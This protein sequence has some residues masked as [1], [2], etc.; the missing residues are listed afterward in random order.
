MASD[1]YA[2]SKGKKNG[3]LSGS[4]GIKRC[5]EMQAKNKLKKVGR[6]GGKQVCCALLKK[7][8]P[9]IER[10]IQELVKAQDD[11]GKIKWA[12][13]I[14]T[15]ARQITGIKAAKKGKSF[16]CPKCKS[17]LE[18]RRRLA[19]LVIHGCRCY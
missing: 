11:S 1:G 6:S 8:K 12:W 16:L 3:V 19:E 5:N 18:P 13:G 15:A 2:E 9:E 14:I 10:Y 17:Y 7:V 4:V